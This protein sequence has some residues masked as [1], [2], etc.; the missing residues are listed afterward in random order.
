MT[1]DSPGSR[2][3]ADLSRPEA[4]PRP[5][6]LVVDDDADTRS[7][8]RQA[9]L[10]M[11]WLVI[12]AEDGLHA[13]ELCEAG[14]PDLIVLDVMMPRMTG[15]EFISWFREAVPSPFI[16]VLMLTALSDIEQK[17]QG[18]TSGADDYIAKPFHY[19]ELQARTQSLL[20]IRGLTN[21]LYRRQEELLGLNA[22]LSAM[23]AALVARER[24]LAVMQLAGA[25]AHGMGQP[26]TTILLHCRL[27]KKALENV[28]SEAAPGAPSAAASALQDGLRSV[29]A[30]QSE[31]EDMAAV[32]SRLRE[33]DPSAV[34]PYVGDTS[35]LEIPRDPHRDGREP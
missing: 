3:A 12:E 5:R 29:A 7:I 35:I 25:A 15:I 10:A 30:I 20:R 19:R 17:V 1:A 28:L 31:C 11:S 32:L 13:K 6:I 24:E 26:L 34:A 9:L 8:I 4:E 22:Q 16:P 14:L 23:Q 18:L 27:L 2:P 33:V 21:D